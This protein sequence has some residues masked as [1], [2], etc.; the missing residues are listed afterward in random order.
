[1]NAVE[2]MSVSSVSN[3]TGATNT[4]IAGVPGQLDLTAKPG[5]GASARTPPPM[6]DVKIIQSLQQTGATKPRGRPAT[7][8]SKGHSRSQS[9]PRSVSR[10]R[11]KPDAQPSR[12]TMSQ[13]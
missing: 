1:M 3:G 5:P 8:D 11:D 9:R 12:Q 2:P 10:S 13:T 7:K 4:N 6:I